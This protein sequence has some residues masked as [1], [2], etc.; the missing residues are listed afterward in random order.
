MIILSLKTRENIVIIMQNKVEIMFKTHFSSLSIVFMN[1][2]ENLFI[3]HRQMM[4]R[5]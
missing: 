2:I 5:Q 4:T 3:F 1:N